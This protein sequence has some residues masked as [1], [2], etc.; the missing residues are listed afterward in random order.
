MTLTQ[1]MDKAAREDRARFFIVAD[2]I[3]LQPK[4]AEHLQEL[5]EIKQQWRDMTALPDYPKMAFPLA[6]P[7]WFP[8]VEF[9]S[10]WDEEYY[11]R[12]VEEYERNLKNQNK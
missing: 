9:K 1:R 5:E 10:K 11:D 6:L 8:K 4:Y 2:A 3:H 12:E 7:E